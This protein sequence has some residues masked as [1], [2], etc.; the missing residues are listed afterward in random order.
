MRFPAESLDEKMK[1]FLRAVPVEVPASDMAAAGAG[2]S[3]PSV[4][5]T[6]VLAHQQH[7][8]AD[9][10]VASSSDDGRVAELG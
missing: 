4:A 6:P 10:A 9:A 1:M 3:T 2:S 7:L 5:A 8:E